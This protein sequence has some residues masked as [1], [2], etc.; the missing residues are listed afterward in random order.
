MSPTSESTPLPLTGGFWSRWMA[1]RTLKHKLTALNM[2]VAAVMTVTMGFLAIVFLPI[3][4]GQIF[5]RDL[6]SVTDII[7]RNVKAA[8][9]FGDQA[10]AADLLKS[11]QV[12]PEITGAW[13]YLPNGDVCAQ[14]S[15]SLPAA[16]EPGR[17]EDGIAR[18]HSGDFYLLRNVTLEDRVLGH[19]IVRADFFTAAA[20]LIWNIVGVGLLVAALAVAVAIYLADR[21]QGVVLDPVLHLA[22]T[23]RRVAI[24]N[25]YSIRAERRTQDELGDLTDSFNQMLTEIQAQDSEL[26]LGQAR[27][28]HALEGAR[29]GFWEVNLATGALLFSSSYERI[30]GYKDFEMPTTIDAYLALVHPEDRQRVVQRRTDY[31]AGVVPT[32]DVEARVRHKDGTYRWILARA[33]AVR[34]AAGHPVR[35]A[36]SHSDI[37]ERRNAEL[38]M[39]SLHHQLLIASR[40][41]GMAEVAT[42]VL[43]NVGNVLNSVNVSANVIANSI[44]QSHVK[45]VA[46]IS[47]LLEAHAA[48]LGDYL[49]TDPRGV[50]V[51]GYLA[52]L[53]AQ[54]IRENEERESEIESLRANVDHIKLIVSM[55]QGLAKSGGWTESLTPQQVLDQALAAINV[56]SLDRHR[57][58]VEKHYEELSPLL[59]DKH[60]VLQILVNFINNAK[61]AMVNSTAERRVLTL[62]ARRITG[63]DQEQI[64]FEVGDTGVGIAP[65][66]GPKI[67]SQ[68]FTTRVDGHGFGLHSGVIAARNMGGALEFASEGPGRGAVFSLILPITSGE[69][70][71]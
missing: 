58:H 7:A 54:L 39:H 33:A 12:K 65:E 46:R 4:F 69:T 8:V 62:R 48:N 9:A 31:L 59:I 35:M 68:G 21:L 15:G 60:Q 25:D 63:G 22:A 11:L 29:D 14:L 26:Q 45:D 49:T 57:I 13:L 37:T 71:A 20:S 55:Q 52:Q 53:G 23:A 10:T 36:G 1:K 44:H 19:L 3:W 50:R 17:L 51:P 6:A 47:G 24:G 61:H 2:A 34:D 67:F 38:E 56:S 42:S 28:Q 27:Y 16:I 41:A 64:R 5:Q 18:F 30:L 32:F 43:H 40:R 66:V 70:A